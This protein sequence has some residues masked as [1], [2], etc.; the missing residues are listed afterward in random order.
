MMARSGGRALHALYVLVAASLAAGCTSAE[1][2]DTDGVTDMEESR[3]E[4][5]RGQTI[6]W[7]FDDG[8][9]AGI[10]FEHSFH[11][12]GTVTWTALGGPME[13]SSATESDYAAV[14]IT[15][16]VHAVS[17]LAASGY[18]LTVVLNFEDMGMTGFASNES[19][20][21][22]ITGTFEAR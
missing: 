13:G 7:T 11:E 22:P 20:W 17:Y 1:R 12:D 3:M 6:R 2:A 19:E 16:T 9:M 15:E 10:P 21:Y 5:L 14:R 8:P 4:R 18:T